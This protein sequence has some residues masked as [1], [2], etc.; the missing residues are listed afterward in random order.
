M[1]T[2]YRIVDFQNKPLSSWTGDRAHL[3][4]YI[5]ERPEDLGKQRV[6]S[7]MDDDYNEEDITSI[8]ELDALHPDPPAYWDLQCGYIGDLH[9]DVRQSEFEEFWH[10]KEFEQAAEAA[11]TQHDPNLCRFCGSNAIDLGKNEPTVSCHGCGREYIDT[12]VN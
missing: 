10:F 4:A 9:L 11:A 2:K 1:T 12:E 5:A 3:D 6:Q 7:T 8:E